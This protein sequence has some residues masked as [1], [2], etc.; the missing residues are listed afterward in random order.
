MKTVLFV[1]YNFPPAGGA[2]VQRSLKFIK[3]LPQFNWQPVVITTT[4]DAYAVCDE[5]LWADVPAHT[6]IYRAKSYDING[7]RSLFTRLRL[8]KLLTILNVALMLPDAAVFWARLARN[9]VR[10]AIK[11]HEPCLIYSSSG[12][13]SAHLLALWAKSEFEL[14][15][16]ADFRDPWSENQLIPYYPG[17][18]AINRRME[19]RVL[20]LADCIVTVSK[21]LADDLSRLS[22]RRQPPVL[23][24]ENGYD[25]DEVVPLPPRPTERFTITYTGTFSRLRRPDALVTA[26]DHLITD[27]Q[28][29]LD[30]ICVAIA[31]KDTAKYI[32]GRPPFEQLGYLKHGEL[33][34]LRLQTNLFLFV[35]DNVPESKGAFSGKLFE[36]LGANRP[37]LAIT[38][39]GNVGAQL[40]ER[41]RAGIAT[42]YDPTEIATAILRYYRVWQS[43]DFGYAPDWNIIRQYTRRNLTARL[44]SEFDRLAGIGAPA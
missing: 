18:R 29:P 36:Y 25:D 38:Y 13:A 43:G 7:H 44:A 5:S 14:P 32:P 42:S 30:R 27:G 15:W 40:V 8:G 10:K 35:Q 33:A 2:G 22:G 12:P 3:Y 11:R 26:I 9:A 4:P 20:S 19:R 6:P 21:P 39:P 16:G 23:V 28:I 34:E 37:T 41:A 24:I 1:A 31:G 17:Y